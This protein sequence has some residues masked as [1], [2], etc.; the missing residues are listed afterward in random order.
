M[1]GNAVLSTFTQAAVVV[2][3][4]L[5]GGLTALVGPGWVIGVDA[6]SFAVLAVSCWAVAR[7]RAGRRSRAAVAPAAPATGAG[8]SS[9]A[10]PGCSGC[11]R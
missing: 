10:S 5:A 6:A 2:G 9:P 1:N 3:P 7:R 4:A 8:A 11:S